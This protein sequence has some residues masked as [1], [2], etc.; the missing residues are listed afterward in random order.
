M[1]VHVVVVEVGK[2]MNQ[3]ESEGIKLDV[4]HQ[5]ALEVTD[6]DLV[7][8]HQEMALGQITLRVRLDL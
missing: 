7:V 3:R 8:G 2:K 1:I 6:E 4:V 5:I